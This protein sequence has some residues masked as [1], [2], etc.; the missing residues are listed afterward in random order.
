[1]ELFIDNNITNPL[2][3]PVRTR[4]PAMNL[5]ER[6]EPKLLPG[7]LGDSDG[8][9]DGNEIGW[10]GDSFGEPGPQSHLLLLTYAVRGVLA[11][12]PAAKND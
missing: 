9:L 4:I 2:F 12:I 8:K 5:M 1:M 10:L 7:S 3:S 11:P 6:I